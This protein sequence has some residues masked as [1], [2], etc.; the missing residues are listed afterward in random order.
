MGACECD[1][2]FVWRWRQKSSCQLV[3]VTCAS[4]LYSVAIHIAQLWLKVA[5]AQIEKCIQVM[6]KS[7]GKRIA[8]KTPTRSSVALAPV[9]GYISP[10]PVG[11]AAPALL[12]ITLRLRLQ[13]VLHM[14]LPMGTFRLRQ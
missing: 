1:K 13:W 3:S 10:A 4:L 2:M 12:W 5:H 9:V 6:V 7:L 14:H 11:N 8:R